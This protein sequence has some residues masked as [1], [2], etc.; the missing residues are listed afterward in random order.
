MQ[1]VRIYNSR[2]T[3][4]PTLQIYVVLSLG[5]I[6]KKKKKNVK[7]INILCTW[8]AMLSINCD[9]LHKNDLVTIA[10]VPLERTV[11]NKYYLCAIVHAINFLRPIKLCWKRLE[12]LLPR[13]KNDYVSL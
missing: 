9:G 6:V 5:S 8:Y 4:V 13:L 3:R 1:H 2:P 10:S 7:N 11:W 12:Y